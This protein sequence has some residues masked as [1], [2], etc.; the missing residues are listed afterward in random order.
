MVGRMLNADYGVAA[1][2][3]GK[4]WSPERRAAAASSAATREGWRERGEKKIWDGMNRSVT[5]C[6]NLLTAS[7]SQSRGQMERAMF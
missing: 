4:K 6:L 3:K 2:E 7:M 5:G 1:V